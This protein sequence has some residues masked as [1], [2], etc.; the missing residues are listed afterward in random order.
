MSN[1]DSAFLLPQ[2]GG[3]EGLG[4]VGDRPQLD[5]PSL[6]KCEKQGH[7]LIERH[8]A[9]P[10]PDVHRPKGGKPTLGR[11]PELI[12]RDVPIVELMREAGPMPVRA[13]P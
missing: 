11:I 3:I 10:A 13:S 5:Q 4:V 8:S 12:D 1:R 6:G 2:P 9:G 7:R